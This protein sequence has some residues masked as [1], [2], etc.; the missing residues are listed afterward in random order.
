VDNCRI[1]Q[2]DIPII[3]ELT[4]GFGSTSVAVVVVI[5]RV[6]A[7]MIKKGNNMMKAFVIAAAA[8]EP[9]SATCVHHQGHG[10]F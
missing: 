4:W 9:Q 10:L 8:D 6:V 2:S 7:I 1:N 3:R 5:E